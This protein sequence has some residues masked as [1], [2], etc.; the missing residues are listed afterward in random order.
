[1]GGVVSS[2]YLAY[3]LAT[4]PKY[5]K[6]LKE[7][8]GISLPK[9]PASNPIWCHAVSV[10]EV[11]AVSELLKRVKEEWPSIP[12]YLSTVTATGQET[13]SA[14]LEGV[15]DAVFYL[16]FDL[17]PVVSRVVNRV[18]PRIFLVAETELWP[19]LITELGERK[20]PQILLNGRL[21]PGSFRNYH[22]FKA[23]MRPLLGRF[24][25]LCMQSRRDT[26]RMV[27]LGAPAEKVLFTGNLKYDTIIASL[28]EIDPQKVR[29]ELGIPVVSK[30][31]AAG[32]THQGEEEAMLDLLRDTPEDERPLLVL[33]PR[34]P[35]RWDE[36]ARLLEGRGVGFVR[37]SS[38]MPVGENQVLLLD[39]LGELARAYSV[40]EV[41]FV[42]GSLVE[43]G[44]HNPLEAAAL[45]VPVVMG[46][47]LFN[48]Q[49]IS[50]ILSEAGGLSMCQGADEVVAQIIY[51]LTHPKEAKAMG[52]RGR[53]VVLQNRGALDRTLQVIAEIAGK[54]ANPPL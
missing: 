40:A 21:S 43:K 41:A 32:S 1:M 26:A 48:F 3:K 52:E 35:E 9:A 19:G 2:P 27:V 18:N 29:E 50:Q 39:T 46:P 22:A 49:E 24:N 34:H 28:D 7:R 33:A 45:G 44:G 47:H 20:I 11:I 16:P 36:V 4:T 54:E 13:A 10:G 17:P 6:G 38:G 51:L 5:R 15:A 30:V 42:G 31:V 25:R 23:F 12:L 37:R 8:L 14:R 53:E